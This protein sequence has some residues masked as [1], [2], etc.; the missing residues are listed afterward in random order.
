MNWPRI[1][2]EVDYEK[3]RREMIERQIRARGVKDER[4][5]NALQQVERHRFMLPGMEGQAYQDSP[6]GIGEKQTISQPYI[7]AFMTEVARIQENSRVLEVGTGSGYQTAV[8]SVL[9][10]EV[11]TIE[12]IES[13]GTRAKEQLELLGFTN[14]HLRIGD[15]Y[16]GWPEAAPFDAILVTAAPLSVPQPLIDQLATGGRLVIPIGDFYQDLELITRTPTAIQKEKLIPVRFV[17][18]TGQAEEK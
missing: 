11:F 13:L 6:H 1:R 2:K 5:L 15:G 4:V 9:A 12:I 18:M 8:L 14:V 7:V 10:K 3:E 17:P 16:S